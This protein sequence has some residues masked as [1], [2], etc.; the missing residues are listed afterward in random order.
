MAKP[1][2]KWA[3]GK[4]QLIEEISSRFPSE[5]QNHSTYIEPFVGG[6]AVLF[7]V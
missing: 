7:H 6:G 5:L 3:G 4:R 1:F 2:L